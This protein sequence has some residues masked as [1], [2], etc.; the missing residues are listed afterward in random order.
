MYDESAGDRQ[1]AARG[2]YP[3]ADSTARPI[4]AE[5]PD[6]ATEMR[7]LAIEFRDAEAAS[8]RAR[9]AYET[10]HQTVLSGIREEVRLLQQQHRDVYNRYSKEAGLV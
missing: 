5:R 8:T 3:A 6:L 1:G 9:S 10:R 2:T 4:R 7:L